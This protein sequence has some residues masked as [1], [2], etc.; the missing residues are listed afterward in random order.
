MH[1][2]SYTSNLSSLWVIENESSTLSQKCGRGGRK[3]I[4]AVKCE[5]KIP[6]FQNVSSKVGKFFFG[7][8]KTYN[9]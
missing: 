5:E 4:C 6:P 3:K 7:E 8:N 9:P 1:A 2:N